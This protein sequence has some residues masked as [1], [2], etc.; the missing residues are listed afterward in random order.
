MDMEHSW[1]TGLR[2]KENL[3]QGENQNF[4]K[5]TNE[6]VQEIRR[7]APNFTRKD[8]AKKY[9]VTRKTIER[10][11]NHRSWKILST[12]EEINRKI[13]PINI[14]FTDRQK[15]EI[16]ELYKTVLPKKIKEIF[17]ISNTH[18]YRILKEQ[19]CSNL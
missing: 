11:I 16:K 1:K 3:A 15:S 9:N 2:K 5:F 13:K 14:K 4:A 10:I 6:Q 8:L 18:L 17:G 19:K 12:E 7:I